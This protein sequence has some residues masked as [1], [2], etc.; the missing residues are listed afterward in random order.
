MKRTTKILVAGMML[1]GLAL[2]SAHGAT[3]VL[4]DNFDVVGSGTGFNLDTGVN[5]G[6]TAT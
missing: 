5:R 4:S 1:A 2:G 3:L 6:I